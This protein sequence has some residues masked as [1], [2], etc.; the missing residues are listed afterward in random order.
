MSRP[1]PMLGDYDVVDLKR[2]PFELL[3]RAT[4]LPEQASAGP[5]LV[6]LTGAL[7]IARDLQ[8]LLEGSELPRG[9]RL[10]G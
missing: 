7:P 2:S 3:R 6:C 8:R 1:A 5:D 9:P 10:G 4:I